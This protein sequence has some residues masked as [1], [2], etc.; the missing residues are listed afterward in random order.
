M[1]AKT[2]AKFDRKLYTVFTQFTEQTGL[3]GFTLLYPVSFF[4]TNSVLQ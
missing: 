1:E 4:Q 3:P 2:I